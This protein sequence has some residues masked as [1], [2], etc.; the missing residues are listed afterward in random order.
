MAE[1]VQ[2]EIGGKYTEINTILARIRR[3]RSGEPTAAERERLA[4]LREEIAALK[5]GEG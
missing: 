3:R 2:Y 1:H 5:R 4:V